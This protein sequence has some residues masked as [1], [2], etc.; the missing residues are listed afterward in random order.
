MHPVDEANIADFDPSLKVLDC[1]ELRAVGRELGGL[2]EPFVVSQARIMSAGGQT[3]F[4]EFIAL[5]WTAA[6]M[7]AMPRHEAVAGVRAAL[8]LARSRGR[9]AHR[10]GCVH[11]DCHPGRSRRVAG[12]DPGDHGQLVHGRVIGPCGGDGRVGAWR[13]LRRR[14]AG[15]DRRSQRGD[16]S[17][18]RPAPGRRCRPPR[19]RRQP[20]P[21]PGRDPAPA[22]GRRHRHLPAPRHP[23]PRRVHFRLG[24]AIRA[25]PG[26]MQRA[27]R[28]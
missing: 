4:G 17:G 27:A 12:R 9:P 22:A 13:R 6:Q 24:L 5:P 2:L 20:R 3:I 11:V 7:A 15:H 18:R 1:D 26:G 14:H 28:P 8:G 21:R 23:L 10:A 25:V 19:A 16:R